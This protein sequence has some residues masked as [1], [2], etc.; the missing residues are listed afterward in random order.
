MSV[1]IT[2]NLSVFTPEERT[3]HEHLWGELQSAML[4]QRQE[5]EAVRYR[6]PADYWLK[7]AQFIAGERRCCPFFDFNLDVNHEGVLWLSIGGSPEA[8]ALLTNLETATS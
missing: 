8:R 3:A 4:E 7:A 2:C 6:L 1:D 5:P